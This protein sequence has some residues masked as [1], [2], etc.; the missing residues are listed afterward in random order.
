MGRICMDLDTGTI[1]HV[2]DGTVPPEEVLA[3]QPVL[4]HR[5]S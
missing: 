5:E 1:V 3:T 2:H 4:E